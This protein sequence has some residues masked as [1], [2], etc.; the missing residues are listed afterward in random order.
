L[1][2]GYSAD[3]FISIDEAPLLVLLSPAIIPPVESSV[4]S[5]ENS[6][7]GLVIE[8]DG[9]F[10]FD[11]H[12]SRPL[13]PTLLKRRYKCDITFIIMAITYYTV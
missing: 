5:V 13:G 3:I 2:Y 7:R 1:D 6:F 10:H 12:L 4:N 9:P 11:S 8:I